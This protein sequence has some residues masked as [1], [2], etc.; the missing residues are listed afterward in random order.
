MVSKAKIG[1]SITPVK[2]T[3]KI[4]DVTTEG[5]AKQM[6]SQNMTN[7]DFRAELV[8]QLA[9]AEII[10][11]KSR[12]GLRLDEGLD[13]TTKDGDVDYTNRLKYV[14][15]INKVIG[16]YAPQ[17]VES[18]SMILNVDIT[19]EELAKKIAELQSELSE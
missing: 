3:K 2:S 7:L 14:Q 1:K 5:S 10:G 9:D 6:T 4:Y 13:A 16:V 8:K 11:T 19:D 12:V 17:K 18:K 15:E